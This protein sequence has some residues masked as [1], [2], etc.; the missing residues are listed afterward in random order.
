MMVEINLKKFKDIKN[1]VE[2]S[3]TLVNEQGLLMLPG[4]CFSMPGFIRIVLC[5][6][7]ELFEVML[8]RLGLFCSEH[9]I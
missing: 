7:V 6:N 2:F 1:D 5:H 9:S 8:E 3:Q 4:K